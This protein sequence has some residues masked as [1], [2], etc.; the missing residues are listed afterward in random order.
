MNAK[1]TSLLL[2]FLIPTSVCGVSRTISNP[3]LNMVSAS[4]S[5]LGTTNPVLTDIG[6]TFINPASIAEIDSMPLTVTQKSI[7]GEF[8]YNV[9]NFGLPV[10]LKLPTS[11]PTPPHRLVFGL[12]YGSVMLNDIPETTLFNGQNW[13]TGSFSSGFEITQLTGAT[14]FYDFF[15]FD[16]LSGGVGLKYV[17]QKVGTSA[18]STFALDVGGILTK[19]IE[20]RFIDNIIIGGAI[21]NLI[22]PP[23]V[24]EENDNEAVLPFDFI[25][26]I[27][28]GLFDESLHLYLNNGIENVT[29]GG[30]YNLA[31]GLYL[32]GSYESTRLSAGTGI[33]FDRVATGFA[34]RDYSL[35]ID[36]NY[37]H[38]TDSVIDADP[39][40]VFSVSLLG[41]S[42]PR[43]PQ[44]LY[45]ND[46]LIV[47]KQKIH[48]L[49][50]L[51]QKNTTVRLYNH[52][53]L[54]QTTV[55]D[56]HGRWEA[57]RFPLKEGKNVIYVKSIDLK[58][59]SSLESNKVV[60]YSDTI[61]P[62]L[63]VE[64]NPL[65]D[66]M[67]E[68]YVN[69]NEQIN[70]IEGRIGKKELN[71]KSA[72]IQADVKK[73]SV[74]FGKTIVLPNRPSEWLSIIPM[75]DHLKNKSYVQGD[76]SYLELNAMDEAGNYSPIQTIPFFFSMKFPNDKYVHY[77]EQLRFIGSGSEAIQSLTINNNA[78]YLDQYKQFA[79]PVNLEPGKN[80]VSVK[81]KTR[82]NQELEY[83]M[84]ILRLVTYPDLNEKVRGRREI[85]F[86][87]TI[88]VLEGN[89]DGNFYPDEPVT[90]EYIAKLMVL[91]NQDYINIV[92]P[93]Y[94]LYPDVLR[95]HPFA[96]YIAAA[97]E[98]GL[99]FAFPDG[100]F[101]PN[102]SLTLAETVF[103]LS[104]AGIIEYQD[105]EDGNSYVT[106]AELA[107]FL[108]Y[109]PEYEERIERLID[110][111]KGYK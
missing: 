67:L 111:E 55:A 4:T 96:K 69:A 25:V 1:Y 32:R 33:L 78:V 7:L 10:K 31:N 63:N 13:Q 9:I 82:N 72:E 97:V 49:S 81:V 92:E 90:R 105:V 85:E 6:A 76:L 3:Q 37:T 35:R 107:E 12:S 22:A 5:A 86:L 26:G 47:T 21:H 94:N 83:F 104:S 110:W 66:D 109:T 89:E 71:F 74:P 45:P 64:I 39:T 8:N 11:R 62:Q 28:A 52:E 24:W 18:E 53:A 40:H 14:S 70:L 57:S 102:Q 98:N 58:T 108:A 99:I 68:V 88:G 103:L 60:I 61:A 38:Y 73:P 15:G 27:G 42:Q 106:R 75:P 95:T 43:E 54:V 84:R 100:T 65:N 50:G 34:Q 80:L 46:Q 19:H 29:L 36:Y 59:D 23:I 30:E 87:S 16:I 79:M 17:S 56:K 51:G 2:L 91:S 41:A 93:T 77:K 44:I 48:P 101:K 20:Y